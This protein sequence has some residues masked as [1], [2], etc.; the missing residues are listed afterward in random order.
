MYAHS[1]YIKQRGKYPSKLTTTE[2]RD[3]L[4]IALNLFGESR[5]LVH[6][7][8]HSVACLI[9]ESLIDDRTFELAGATNIRVWNR[10][11]GS[12]TLF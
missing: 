1:T 5:E 8:R 7:H 12:I 9:D 4:T 2:T 10:N 3:L 11:A 6:H